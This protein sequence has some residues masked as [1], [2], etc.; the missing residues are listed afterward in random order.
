M[1]HEVMGWINLNQD[2]DQWWTVVKML[3]S[4]YISIIRTVIGI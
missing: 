3:T 2:R 1:V 4:L